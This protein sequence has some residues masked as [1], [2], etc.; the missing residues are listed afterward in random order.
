MR[1]SPMPS[2]KTLSAVF[3]NP[4]LAREILTM[5]HAT[6]AETDGGKARIAECFHHPKWYDVRLHALDHIEPS[7]FGVEACQARNG[8]FADYLN[9]GDM[10]DTTL[11]YWRGRYRVQSLGE[12]IETMERNGVKFD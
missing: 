1:K 6:L 5:P 4:K 7:T 12:F 8:E 2:V 11:I 10:Y 3:D 9:T